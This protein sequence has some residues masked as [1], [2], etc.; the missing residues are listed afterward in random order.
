MDITFTISEKD[1]D[2]TEFIQAA[3][4]MSQFWREHGKEIEEG[5]EKI[6]KLQFQEKHISCEINPD[7]S[8]SE[9]SVTLKYE[10]VEDMKDNLIHELIHTLFNQNYVSVIKERWDRFFRE[11]YQDEEPV[12][13][14]HIIIHAVHALLYE[15]FRPERMPNIKN[16]SVDKNY[17][18][19]WVIAKELG[20]QNVVNL[21]Y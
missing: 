5:L 3:K 14:T 12:T 20:Y 18:R 17:Q 13:R 8:K 15:T 4:Q 11:M 19:S 10:D 2:S 16:F 1:K 9:P 7:R 6:T 21:I